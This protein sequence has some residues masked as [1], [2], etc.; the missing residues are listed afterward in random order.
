MTDYLSIAVHAFASYVLMSFSV[1]ETVER[2][3]LL[4][5]KNVTN[6]LFVYK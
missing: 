1:E 5:V 4:H 2:I 3:N 6:K